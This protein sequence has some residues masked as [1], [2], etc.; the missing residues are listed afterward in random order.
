MTEPE[1][2]LLEVRGLRVDYGRGRRR[3]TAVD[4]V[5]LDVGPGETLALVGES[6]SGKST[7][8][9]AVLGLVPIAAGTVTF[10]GEDVGR[11]PARRRRELTAQLQAVFQDPY[12]SLNSMRTIR[13]TLVEPLIAHRRAVPSTGGTSRPADPASA[14]SQVEAALHSVGL[15]PDAADRYPGEFSGGQRQRIA[16]ARALMLRPRLI[17]CDEPTSALDLSVQAQV[18]NLLTTLQRDLGLSYLFI[19][20]DLAIIRH[21]AHRVAVLH[22]GRVV[23]TGPVRKVCDEPEDPYTQALLA[24]APVPDPVAQRERREA[25]AAAL[26]GQR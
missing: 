6:G 14:R 3:S 7:I 11:A 18:L 15:D 10:Q 25:R 1:R 12:G 21:V 19:T 13:Q 20:H 9:N 24:A 23:E 2:A 8:G 17:V 16:V 4:A 26:A 5:D 22:R